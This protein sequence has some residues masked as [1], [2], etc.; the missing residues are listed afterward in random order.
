MANMRSGIDG[1]PST[2]PATSRFIRGSSILAAPLDAPSVNDRLRFVRG[3][4]F[5]IVIVV[6]HTNTGAGTPWDATASPGQTPRR[7]TMGCR[8]CA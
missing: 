1:A 6:P 3:D 5:M 7:W 8:E 2:A 4:F